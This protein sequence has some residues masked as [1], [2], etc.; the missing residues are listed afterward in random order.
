M[1]PGNIIANISDH[2][3]QFFF[4]PNTLSSPSCQKLIFHESNWSKF[5][6]QYFILDYF[7]EERSD[8]LQLDQQN[9]NIPIECFLNN[10]KMV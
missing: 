5:I 10:M 1:I 6:Q 4:A 2:L 8:L 9:I 7:D 3:L